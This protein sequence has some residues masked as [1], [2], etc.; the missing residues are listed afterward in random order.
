MLYIPFPFELI[1]DYNIF[2]QF[3]GFLP[4]FDP[5][6]QTLTLWNTNRTVIGNR[7]PLPS[8]WSTIT[9]A[10]NMKRE[11]KILSPKKERGLYLRRFIRQGAILKMVFYRFAYCL[12][13]Y[14]LLES[15]LLFMI[16]VR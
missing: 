6:R 13:G 1:L 5:L 3:A 15:S 7:S 2:E 4:F 9:A 16:F 10:A 8:L 11:S 12:D 14:F